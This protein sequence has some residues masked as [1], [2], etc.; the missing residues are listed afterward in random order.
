MFRPRSRGRILSWTG[1][2]PLTLYR[3]DPHDLGQARAGLRR[4]GE[5]L[6]AGGAEELFLPIRAGARVRSL[7]ELDAAIQGIGPRDLELISVHAMASCPMG[8]H[9]SSGPV[10]L[11]GRL[12][13]TRNVSVADASI[14]PGNIGESPQ[15]TI[16]AFVRESTSRRLASSG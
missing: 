13:G 5:L 1:E 2:R 12:R 8:S 6:F 15:G 10:D 14:L 16:M 11:E 3:F 4:A 7:G 9:A